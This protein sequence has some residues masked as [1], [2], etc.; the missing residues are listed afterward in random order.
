VTG[1]TTPEI[2]ETC[3]ACPNFPFKEGLPQ[4]IRD[5]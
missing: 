2:D 3:K 1:K 4:G 5:D